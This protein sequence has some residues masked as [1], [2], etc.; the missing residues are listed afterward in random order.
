[1]SSI[2][3]SCRQHLSPTTLLVDRF[4]PERSNEICMYLY[5]PDCPT[6]VL[7]KVTTPRF[8]P[9]PIVRLDPAHPL[10]LV[11]RNHHP[12]IPCYSGGNGVACTRRAD[13]LVSTDGIERA[14]EMDFFCARHKP[15]AAQLARRAAPVYRVENSPRCGQCAY[16]CARA[17]GAVP[18]TSSKSKAG[19]QAQDGS[20]TPSTNPVSVKKKVKKGA[21]IAGH[22]PQTPRTKK[23]AR[24]TY[25]GR[26][27]AKEKLTMTFDD[28]KE[29]EPKKEKNLTPTIGRGGRRSLRLAVEPGTPS[30]APTTT[31]PVGAT[32]RSVGKRR[33]GEGRIMVSTPKRVKEESGGWV[34][35]ATS[36]AS[37]LW[38]KT[39]GGWRVGPHDR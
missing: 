17:P 26:H 6:E 20:R 22:I 30:P 39:L 14:E 18:G 31:T 25:A 21:R 36:V 28:E 35:S 33:R 1:M 38:G 8:N 16:P 34:A 4:P 19:K 7:I 27:C 2:A 32:P 11:T 5:D 10:R 37:W 9:R 29:K 13:I 15:S 3:G 24:E 12:S 23:A